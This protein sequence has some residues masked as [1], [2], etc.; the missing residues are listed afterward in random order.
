MCLFVGSVR[1]PSNLVVS[2]QMVKNLES[3]YAMWVKVIEDE[4]QSSDD[5]NN[6]AVDASSSSVNSNVCYN[7]IYLFHCFVK[8]LF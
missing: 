5:T 1:S 7:F 3:N 2:C 8:I 6:T 4:T